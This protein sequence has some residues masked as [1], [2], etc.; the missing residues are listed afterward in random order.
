VAVNEPKIENLIVCNVWL[1]GSARAIAQVDS[2]SSDFLI[3]QSVPIFRSFL[4]GKVMTQ[5]LTVLGA[6]KSVNM[7]NIRQNFKHSSSARLVDR[8]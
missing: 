4:R 1:V 8:N 2:L 6:A 7:A 5:Q 3:Q